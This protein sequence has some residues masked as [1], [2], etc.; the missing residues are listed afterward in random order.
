MKIVDWIKKSKARIVA[1]M[2]VFVV[3]MIVFATVFLKIDG[4]ITAEVDDGVLVRISF[5]KSTGYYKAEAND[6]WGYTRYFEKTD[7]TESGWLEVFPI[8]TSDMKKT[9]STYTDY[10]DNIIKAWYNPVDEYYETER[11]ENFVLRGGV[12]TLVGND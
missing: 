10:Y 3:I 2:C 4:T 5:D 6:N 7:E 11:E 9:Y 12:W 1:V 8:P